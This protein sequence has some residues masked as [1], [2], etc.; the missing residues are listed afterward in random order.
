MWIL[1]Q[2]I[3]DVL[4][5]LS[6]DSEFLPPRQRDHTV[7]KFRCDCMKMKNIVPPDTMKRTRIWRK[8]TVEL[9]NILRPNSLRMDRKVT[10]SYTATYQ[11]MGKLTTFLSVRCFLICNIGMPSS[12]INAKK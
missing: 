11:F 12:A 6:P 2:M 4:P 5:A 7:K 8:V 1:D 10:H 3:A 9:S